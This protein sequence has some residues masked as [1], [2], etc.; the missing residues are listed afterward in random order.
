MNIGLSP[1]PFCCGDASFEC[2]DAGA[3]WIDCA[4]CGAST[5]QRYSTG[6]D[7]LPLLAEQ[8][9]RRAAQQVSNENAPWL[10][11]AH[12]ICTE[13]LIPNGPIGGRLT[14]LRKQL[15]T[16]TEIPENC[17]RFSGVSKNSGNLDTSADSSS[18]PRI[19]EALILSVERTREDFGATGDNY[20]AIRKLLAFAEE[21]IAARGHGK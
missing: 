15:S 20:P 21:A 14:A 12:L 6:E 11:I 13:S 3:N 8:W 2:D 7:C 18:Q 17:T 5:C 4:Q 16:C 9:N 19:D 1:C 10:T